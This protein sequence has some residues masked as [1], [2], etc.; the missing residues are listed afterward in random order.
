MT[1]SYMETE[2]CYK[3]LGNGDNLAV[4]LHGWGGGSDLI[5]SLARNL[6]V[7]T[8]ITCLLIDFPPFGESK[9]PKTTWTLENYAEMTTEIIQ[10]VIKQKSFKSV[11]LIGHSFG[12]RICILLASKQKILIDKVVLIGS[13]GIKPRFNLQTKL[14]IIKYKIYRRLGLKKAGS[15]GSADYIK[16][17]D[18]MKETFKNIV[19]TDLTN[20]LG[21]ITQKTFIIFGKNDKET[22]VYMAKKL[23]KHIANSKL[24]ILENAG[25]FVYLDREVEVAQNISLFLNS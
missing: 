2:I 23:H 25:H 14:K 15:M 18:N 17:P 16:L 19:N 24:L 6:A 9:S 21:E 22:P 1:H 4:F 10:K 11:N 20:L 5:L 7:L 13:A 3:T 8:D 12:G